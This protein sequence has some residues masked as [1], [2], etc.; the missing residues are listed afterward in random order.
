MKK[1]FFFSVLATIVFVTGCKSK[2]ETEAIQNAKEVQTIVKNSMPGTVPTTADGYTMRAKINGQEW[3]A[4]EMMPPEV[5]S[6]IIGSNNDDYISFPYDRRNMVVGDKIKFGDRTSPDMFMLGELWGAK[7]G[8]IE[9]TKV[10]QNYAEGKFFF[11][12]SQTNSEKTV[13]VTDGFFRV[14]FK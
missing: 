13:A 3:A 6:R 4:T 12:A 5:P 2:A 11:T 9:I 14:L 10:E 1:L 7:T 8:E